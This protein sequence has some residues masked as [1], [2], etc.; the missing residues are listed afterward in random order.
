[1]AS[2]RE[3][4]YDHSHISLSVVSG[5]IGL[6]WRRIAISPIIH[7]F[8]GKKYWWRVWIRWL[9]VCQRR[10]TN[11]SRRGAGPQQGRRWTAYI[12][13][14]WRPRRKC[15]GYWMNEISWRINGIRWR[16][17][18]VCW[19]SSGTRRWRRARWRR[20]IWPTRLKATKV[21]LTWWI[22]QTHDNNV[23]FFKYFF[24]NLSTYMRLKKNVCHVITVSYGAP[25]GSIISLTSFSL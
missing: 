13:R 7:R 15:N 9:S 8:A 1:M 4:G 6:D 19:L 21:C 12:W 11:V 5:H 18:T 20:R 2:N 22:W 23:Y 17:T 10:S 16:S 3:C 14:P 25:R 24:C